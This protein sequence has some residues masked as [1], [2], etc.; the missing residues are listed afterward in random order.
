MTRFSVILQAMS[1]AL[2]GV[3]AGGV[4]SAMHPVA[5]RPAA[6]AGPGVEAVGATAAQGTGGEE[7]GAAS[8]ALGLEITLDQASELFANGTPFIDARLEAEYEA[9]HVEG[10]FWLPASEFM[11]GS[12]PRALDYLDPA[13]PLVVY[14]GGGDCDA[15]HNVVVLLQRLG[16]TRC[17]VMTEGY[18]AWVA[19]GK[20]TGMGNPA[21]A[22]G[23]T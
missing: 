17:H 13:A 11:G 9:G 16:F 23:G 1:I 18:P 4:H 12:S 14:C 21:G 22:G 6:P 19:A 3:V 10:A 15:S 5:L 2:V 8:P 7:S 20:P